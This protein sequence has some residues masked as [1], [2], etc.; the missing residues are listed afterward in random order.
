MNERP[1]KRRGPIGWLIDNQN[2]ILA[3][4][5]ASS[6]ILIVVVFGIIWV[7]WAVISGIGR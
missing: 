7:V 6:P 3:I 5:M 2:L 4:L 1:T